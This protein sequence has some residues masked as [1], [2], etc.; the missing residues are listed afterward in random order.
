[1]N[2]TEF[3][4]YLKTIFKPS[5]VVS[6]ENEYD[7]IDFH[8]V[9]SPNQTSMDTLHYHT[10]QQKFSD[11]SNASHIRSSSRSLDSS[12][13]FSIDNSIHVSSDINEGRNRHKQQI[14]HLRNLVRQQN[15]ARQKCKNQL[16]EREKL[17]RINTQGISKLNEENDALRIK[18]Q[19]KKNRINQLQTQNKHLR[20]KPQ[21]VQPSSLSSPSASLASRPVDNTEQIDRLKGIIADL[22]RQK[23][24]LLGMDENRQAIFSKLKECQ[25]MKRKDFEKNPRMF[26]IISQI[27]LILK[28]GLIDGNIRKKLTAYIEEQITSNESDVGEKLKFYEK[29]QENEDI[30]RNLY[31]VSDQQ[32][33]TYKE[34]SDLGN[35]LERMKNLLELK[36][37]ENVKE[38]AFVDRKRE[39]VETQKTSNLLPYIYLYIRKG[40]RKDENGNLINVERIFTLSNKLK[41]KR[42]NYIHEL[43]KIDFEEEL[44]GK[45][46]FVKPEQAVLL[47]RC[48]GEVREF[49]L[50]DKAMKYSF[51]RNKSVETGFYDMETKANYFQVLNIS[52]KPEDMLLVK[53]NYF[54]A[55]YLDPE[56]IVKESKILLHEGLNWTQESSSGFN[57]NNRLKK[58]IVALRDDTQKSWFKE[59]SVFYTTT[60]QANTTSSSTAGS[61]EII[62][63]INGYMD[64]II[65]IVNENLPTKL[66]DLQKIV[67]NS[68]KSKDEKTIDIFFLLGLS[69]DTKIIQQII[70]QQIEDLS[71]DTEIIQQIKDLSMDTKIIQQIEDKLIKTIIKNILEKSDEMKNILEKSDE[72][73]NIPQKSD[74]MK[75][76]QR[77]GDK[78]KDILSLLGLSTTNS[79]EKQTGFTYLKKTIKDIV[80]ASEKSEEKMKDIFILFGLDIVFTY[81]KKTIKDIVE[82]SG[83]SKEKMKDIFILFGLDMTSCNTQEGGYHYMDLVNKNFLH[84]LKSA[85]QEQEFRLK[86]DVYMQLT[87]DCIE[88][89]GNLD[90][91]LRVSFLETS[92]NDFI[93]RKKESLGMKSDLEFAYMGINFLD[94]EI[95]DPDNPDTIPEAIKKNMTAAE[96]DR[97]RKL[98][99]DLQRFQRN[100][101]QGYGQWKRKQQVSQRNRRGSQGGGRGPNPFA[102]GANP[103]A[104]GPNPFAGGANPFAAG[105]NLKKVKQQDKGNA[106]GKQDAVSSKSASST[107]TSQRPL[108]L[109]NAINAKRI[110]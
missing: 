10:G 84:L 80:E 61:N 106:G 69:M 98:F 66:D 97:E 85:L 41:N 34:N 47:A 14:T 40:T 104:G 25:D 16:D 72:M 21:P 92:R 46:V 110:D 63:P 17:L 56:G 12:S 101:D 109:L 6:C 13:S 60:A 93:R 94:K 42:L 87:E 32:M 95:R 53:D 2:E 58:H 91:N 83:K 27:E 68:S 1:M 81:L 31:K 38:I 18:V 48:L 29:Y 50:S 82:A 107:R 108:S 45:H 36:F 105:G 49:I 5:E 65:D 15:S 51:L 54:F 57:L 77:Y 71:M 11:R 44:K 102:G 79:N 3:I 96:L 73:K 78:T 43:E 20:N 22:Q 55:I 64:K 7:K 67:N 89:F 4:R 35:K 90:Y 103:F 9:R 88:A 37:T 74:E 19:E 8:V 59:E 86:S 100:P 70:I 99:G 28:T 39:T 24:E 62:I 30:L 26:K 52:I 75:N 23:I 76:I 33:I